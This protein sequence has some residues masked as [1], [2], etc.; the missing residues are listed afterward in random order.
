MNKN[1]I[2]SFTNQDVSNTK[3]SVIQDDDNY[4]N[5]NSSQKFTK[6]EK[7]KFDRRANRLASANVKFF[8]NN[9]L[10]KWS[11]AHDKA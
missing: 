3:H 1:H 9:S 6:E 5:V 10:A 4:N 2:K 7:L 8:I 11:K